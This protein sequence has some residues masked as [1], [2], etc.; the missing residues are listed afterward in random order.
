VI[1][2]TLDVKRIYRIAYKLSGKILVQVEGATCSGK[3]S[4][5]SDI[6]AALKREGINVMFI[7]EA[8]KK[9]LTENIS[10]LEQL[11]NCPAKSNQWKKSKIELQQK[12]LFHQLDSLEQFA[13]NGVYKVA[14]MD[15]GGASTAY[16]SIP[17]L[18]SK[19]KGW[20]EEICRE[21][22]KM[23]SQIILLSPLGF[24][25]K[26]SPRYQKTLEE[27]R[28]EYGGIKHFLNSWELDYLEISSVR[29]DTRVKK[30]MKC[31][32]NLLNK[33]E[34]KNY[35]KASKCSLAL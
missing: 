17:L 30:G 19:E 10:L 5:V 1:V 20:M 14:L 34:Q 28:A 24:I 7:E 35:Q 3:S 4:F 23:S 2:D 31:I 9:I 15:R 18:S 27:I 12:V 11:L 8:A 32:F 22:G 26:D 21:M 25:D 6:Y 29:R 33:T 13:E 16:H